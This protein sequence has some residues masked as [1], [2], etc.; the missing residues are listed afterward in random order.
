M[1]DMIQEALALPA[2]QRMLVASLLASVACGLIGCYVVT[3]R[4][5]SL[6][7]G[8]SHAAFGGRTTGF[9]SWETNT[10]D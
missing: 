2:F 6:T 1:I 8:I 10:N 4:I 9:R 5:S 7:G 3:K